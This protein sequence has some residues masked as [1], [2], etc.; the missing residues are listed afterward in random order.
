LSVVRRVAGRDFLAGAV[1]LT[2]GGFFA[3]YALNTL[4]LGTADEMGPGY[5]PLLAGGL[6][7]FLGL[8][9]LIKGLVTAGGPPLGINL[10]G[11]ALIAV[12]PILFGLLVRP[13]GMIPALVV[14][15]LAAS[16]ASRTVVPW[17]AAVT[18]A[19]VTALCVLVFRFALGLNLALVAWPFS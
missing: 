19:A 10:R 15:L 14:A 11:L 4:R 18:A 12:A 7:A 3:V 5:F 17:Q 2:C 16:F 8:V 9:I 6:L 13:F 1:F